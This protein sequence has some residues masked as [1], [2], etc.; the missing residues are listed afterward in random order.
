MLKLKAGIKRL[1]NGQATAI[2]ATKE[3][4][5]LRLERQTL[6]A[7]RHQATLLTNQKPRQIRSS[8]AGGYLS[9]FRG[10]GSE[11]DE[12][13]PYQP[14]DDTR[15]IDWRVSAR[16]GRTYTK[17][18]REERECPLLIALD[19]RRPMH[20]GSRVTFK[21]L[22]ALQAGTLLAWLGE[23]QGDRIGLSIFNEAHHHELRPKRGQKAVLHL[24]NLLL[25]N[26]AP[27]TAENINSLDRELLRLQ[28]IS[29]TGSR[30]Y[31]LSDFHDL[32][33]AAV[34]RLQGLARHSEIVCLFIYDPL[35][36]QLP[37]HGHY[38]VSD[39]Q[40]RLTLTGNSQLASAFHQQFEQ[41]LKTLQELAQRQVIKL[42]P[43]ATNDPMIEQLQRFAR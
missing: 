27:S 29:K 9:R 7:L 32:D 38:T 25:E 34:K 5:P 1:F 18:F 4:G 39:G 13:R 36:A 35:E 16:S 28:T 26:Q 23:H 24:I 33:S 30:I 12:V 8:Q 43:L 17:L 6:L 11:F 40:Q 15:D 41:R 21:S 14:G 20:F 10:R 31:L 2:E 37:E 3:A 22:L 19:L 42:L